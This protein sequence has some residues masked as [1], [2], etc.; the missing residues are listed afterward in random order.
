MKR[1]PRPISMRVGQLEF[2]KVNAEKQEWRDVYHWVLSLSW[3]RFALLILGVYL[4][5]N[6]IFAG[7]Y[8]MGGPCIAEMVPGSFLGAFFFSAETLATVGYGHMYPQTIYGHAICT[9]EI[10]AGM[11]WLAVITGLIF[12][13]FSRPTARI[14][15][16]DSLVI[17]P[18]DGQPTLMLRVANL[19][20]H[21]MV[22]AEFR[23]MLHR[24]ETIQEGDVVR[25]FYS[26]K[27]H[28]DRL[29]A[30]PA[31]LTLRHTI[32]RESPLHG[33]TPELLQ[34]SDTRLMAS[35]VCVETVIP[36]AVQS[37][38][39]YTW[40]DIRFG[41]RFVEIY[42]ELSEDRVSVDYGRIHE[43]EPVLGGA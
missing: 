15:F 5:L 35:V 40:R 14:L 41:E 20:H 9:V 29:I 26:L 42:T 30:F 19:R 39:G 8:A 32:D 1:A 13:R 24:D 18:F 2:L 25:R 3:P 22:E 16:S 10:V 31:A 4:T 33:M 17:A 23:L 43:T 7:L 6:L 21:S 11:F 34:G 28:F 38:H 27:L 36:A 12:V 37:Q